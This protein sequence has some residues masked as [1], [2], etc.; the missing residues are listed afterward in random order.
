VLTTRSAAAL[1]ILEEF[2]PTVNALVL[3]SYP[4]SMNE[5]SSPA[6]GDAGRVIVTAP[7]FVFTKSWSPDTAV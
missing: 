5:T 4:W 3:K 1:A 2:L 6:E 7:P